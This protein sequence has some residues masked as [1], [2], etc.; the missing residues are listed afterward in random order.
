MRRVFG[1]ELCD[2]YLSDDY[3]GHDDATYPDKSPA[4]MQ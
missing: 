4:S 1:V 2:G 3:I